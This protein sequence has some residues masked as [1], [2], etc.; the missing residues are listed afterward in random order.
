[1]DSRSC[2][3]VIVASKTDMADLRVVSAQKGLDFAISKQL[4][5]YE[6]P[7]KDDANIDKLSNTIA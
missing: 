4:E 6:V 2:L 5:Y 7:A 1:M 3:I